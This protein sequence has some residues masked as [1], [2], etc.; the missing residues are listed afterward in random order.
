MALS[1]KHGLVVW[2]R[3]VGGANSLNVLDVLEI[4]KSQDID[5][6]IFCNQ[7][8]FQHWGFHGYNELVHELY[9]RN[10]K[11]IVVNGCEEIYAPHSTWNLEYYTYP[12]NTIARAYYRIFDKD[13]LDQ[14]NCTRES[15]VISN[16]ENLTYNYHFISMNNRAHQHRMHMIDMVAK[17]NLIDNNAISWHNAPPVWPNYRYQYYDGKVRHLS[18]LFIEDREQAVVPSEYYQSFAQLVI[19]S[20]LDALIITE[21]TATPLIL[22]K[23]FLS[24]STPFF[25]KHLQN[26]G[27]VLY[28]EI[29]DYSFDTVFDNMTRF[30]MIAQNF[31]R[32][33]QIPL[34][35]L[36][37]L[38]KKI[39]DK[40]EHNKQVFEQVIFRDLDNYPKPIQ[41]IIKIYEEEQIEL[42]NLTISH[43]L[44]LKNAFRDRYK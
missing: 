35:Q 16:P 22:G 8:E 43:H 31:H 2:N 44:R 20:T 26:L 3:W 36:N 18:D 19:E 32:L 17:Y 34:Y 37:D 33:S 9:K 14:H 27:F 30:D 23:P 21:K 5:K 38:A 7:F 41:E 40:I 42:D 6:V 25:H 29:F 4:V 1:T 28:D 10:K 12:N 15:R 11:L 13:L 24:A 39:K